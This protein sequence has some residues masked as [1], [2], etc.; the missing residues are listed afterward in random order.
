[1]ND[2]VKQ[3]SEEVAL[4]RHGARAPRARH[5]GLYARLREKAAIDYR[6]PGSLRT[7]V[8]EETIRG[9][10]R[11]YRKGGKDLAVEVLFASTAVTELEVRPRHL[12]DLRGI[13]LVTG[14]PGGGKTTI[15]RKMAASLHSGLYRVCYV[16][17]LHRQRDGH[18]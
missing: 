6:I 16:P 12:L 15:C 7:H 1:V 2:D 8:A 9:W 14:E 4:F 10:L 17:A 3:H 11:Q 5:E 13:G 18:L